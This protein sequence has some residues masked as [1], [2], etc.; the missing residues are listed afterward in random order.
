MTFLN[1]SELTPEKIDTILVEA[2][3]VELAR[4]IAEQDH[5]AA[6]PEDKIDARISVLEARQT[7]I[8]RGARGV[9]GDARWPGRRGRSRHG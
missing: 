9:C 6:L 3:R 1:T 2:L 4:I 8:R 7:G 5:G